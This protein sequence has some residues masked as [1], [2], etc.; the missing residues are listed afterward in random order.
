M[1]Y[2]KKTKKKDSY[3]TTR[4]Y[5]SVEELNRANADMLYR[6]PNQKRQSKTQAMKLHERYDEAYHRG[7]LSERLPPTAY[8][9]YLHHTHDSRADLLRRLKDPNETVEVKQGF[10]QLPPG[11]MGFADRG[12]TRCLLPNCNPIV[13]PSLTLGRDQFEKEEAEEDMSAKEKRYTSEVFFSRVTDS[14][15]MDGKVAMKDMKQFY[16]HL[17]FS[18]A[19]CNTANKPLAQPADWDDYVAICNS[20]AAVAIEEMEAPRKKRRRQ[21]LSIQQLRRSYRKK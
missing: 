8:S 18:H 17:A 21:V 9:H 19:R 5:W 12:F 1:R 16:P 2:E 4:R 20:E 7:P 13:T 15:V 14:A 10:Q 11:V 3:Y 6:G